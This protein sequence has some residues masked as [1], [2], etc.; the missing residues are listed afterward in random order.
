TRNDVSL[1]AERAASPV[2]K[3]DGVFG[4]SFFAML[5]ES[6]L[7]QFVDQLAK[8]DAAR[9]PHLW[10]HADRR[11]AGNGV[12]L[13]EIELG[14]LLLEQEVDAR[15]SGDLHRPKRGYRIFLNRLDLSG[16]ELRGNKQL[17]A[18]FEV[19]CSVVVKLAVGDDLAGNRSLRIMI[20]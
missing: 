7:D 14:A 20:A 2:R 9:F 1:V 15:H 5:F 12:H 16:L 6:K 18:V 13:V 8:W 4:P 19:L 17:R 3:L 11:E 10:I